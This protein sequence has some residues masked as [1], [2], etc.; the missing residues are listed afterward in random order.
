MA[1]RKK[2][3]RNI[4]SIFED[5]LDI[6]NFD[7]EDYFNPEID[8]SPIE[9]DDDSDVSDKK[10]LEEEKYLFQGKLNDLDVWLKHEHFRLRRSN[11]DS[12]R[13]LREENAR[14]AFIFSSCWA[15]LIA[16]IIIAKAVFPC[17]FVMSE[18]EYIATIGTLSITILTYYLL[19]VKFLFT[20]HQG[21]N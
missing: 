21:Q 13:K 17:Y 1:K 18:N 6:E 14:K 7:F 5:D 15:A 8:P 2:P 4:D 3:N 16:L 11:E 12:E 19:V 9:F 20:R 10:S